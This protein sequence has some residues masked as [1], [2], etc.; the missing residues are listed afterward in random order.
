VPITQL[1]TRKRIDNSEADKFV[2]VL[3]GMK[4]SNPWRG[5]GSAMF[6]ELGTLRPTASPIHKHR[7]ENQP[8]GDITI[9]VEWSWRIEDKQSIIVGSWNQNEEIDRVPGMLEH[10]TINDVKFFGVL[11]EL[12]ISFD[13]GLYFS[14]F[15][16]VDGDPEWGIRFEDDTWMG[17]EDGSFWKSFK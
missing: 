9:M 6:L 5:Y 11:K 15:S 17:F 8:R 7:F 14:S 12:E 3:R 4:V 1:R 10:L 16:T 13:G 2:Q